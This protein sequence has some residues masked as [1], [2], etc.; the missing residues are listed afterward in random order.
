MFRR[1]QVHEHQ[2]ILPLGS[3]EGVHE[4]LCD[5]TGPC[6][7]GGASVDP[8]KGRDEVRSLSRR[9]GEGDQAVGLL[10]P[11][12]GGNAKKTEGPG[13]DPAGDPETKANGA[14]DKVDSAGHDVEREGDDFPGKTRRRG[15]D[16]GRG[17]GGGRS[18]REG[19]GGGGRSG[20]GG[21]GGG[22][23]RGSM[24]GERGDC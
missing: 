17:G 23:G 6:A 22:G 10:I 12:R 14:G 19:N 5:E 8:L 18:D 24:G 3:M 13:Q 20:R 2:L 1:V 9:G 11:R 15:G 16:C 21:N 7:G 4:P